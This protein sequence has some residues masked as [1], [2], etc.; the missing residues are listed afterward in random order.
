MSRAALALAA[1]L[2]AACGGGEA[3]IDVTNVMVSPEKQRAD[4][5]RARDLGVI[6]DAE[7]RREVQEIGQP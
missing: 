6:T 4:L 1:L 2:L 3:A 7:Y 5:A